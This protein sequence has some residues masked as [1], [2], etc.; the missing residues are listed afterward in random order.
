MSIAQTALTPLPTVPAG[1]APV[2]VPAPLPRRP[3]LNLVD[4]ALEAEGP[5]DPA[6][7]KPIPADQ[8]ANLPPDLRAELRKQASDTWVRGIVFAPE[9]EGAAWLRDPSDYT[10]V[11]DPPLSAP[12]GLVAAVGVPAGTVPAGATSY[13]VTAL[14]GNGET[15]ASPQAGVT[16]TSAGSV[17]LTWAAQGNIQFRVYGRTA[18]GLG[19]LAVVGPFPTGTTPTYTDT[20]TP[21]PGA[22]PPASNTTG[23]TGAY[24]NPSLVQW[25]PPLI[26]TGARCSSFGWSEYDFVGRAQRWADCALPEAIE[27]EFCDG[28]LTKAKG[29]GNDYLSNPATVTDLTPGA[30]PSIVRGL[31]MMQSALANCGFG[32]QG[33]IHVTA[34]TTPSLLNVRRIGNLLLDTSDNFIVPGVGYTG[35]GPGGTTPPAGVAYIYATDLVTVRYEEEATV[36]PE[37][38]AEALDRGQASQPNNIE[39]RAMRFGGAYMPGICHFCTQVNLPA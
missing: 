23:G 39:F 36:I 12:T 16:L 35:K 10:S 30:V 1:R 11:D 3:P 7:P 13:A 31:N 14:N 6:N 2:V 5:S 32:G 37:T 15:Q 4:I 28:A 27:R 33:M 24:Q 17:T 18:A 26:L 9:Q 34:S 22:A 8:L 25:I 20:G 38:F 19:V 29:Y 21:A